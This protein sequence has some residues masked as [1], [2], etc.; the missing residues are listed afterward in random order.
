V[1]RP[2]DGGTSYATPIEAPAAETPAEE[3]APVA[4]AVIAEPAAAKKSTKADEVDDNDG[5]DETGDGSD[6]GDE[7]LNACKCD[8]QPCQDGDH[9]NCSAKDKCTVGTDAKAAAEQQNLLALERQRIAVK[10]AL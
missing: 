5:S 10:L 3:S 7:D 8:C 9:V 1:A 6:D 4:E 2:A